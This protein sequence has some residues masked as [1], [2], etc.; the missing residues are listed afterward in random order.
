MGG[1]RSRAAAHEVQV[2]PVLGRVSTRATPASI[3]NSF[4]SYVGRSRREGS[5]SA[6]GRGSLT[7]VH[8]LLDT[9][10]LESINLN[11]R[12]APH[13]TAA[14]V[15]HY[16]SR[17]L[18]SRAALWVVPLRGRR[19]CLDGRTAVLPTLQT[20]GMRLAVKTSAPR[21]PLPTTAEMQC[22][23]RTWAGLGDPQ[24]VGIRMLSKLYDCDATEWQGSLPLFAGL[25]IAAQT[26]HLIQM[27][28][29][30]IGVLPDLQALVPALQRLGRRHLAYNV[31]PRH[32]D[33]MGKALLDAL[34][35]EIGPLFTT[36]D[37]TNM[38]KVYGLFSKAMKDGASSEAS[39]DEWLFAFAP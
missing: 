19:W 7:P 34:A 32:Y 16:A 37:R 3:E 1:A 13:T 10:E 30:A 6:R 4:Y 18:G 14:E 21:V 9:G 23:K 33:V 2:A 27:L 24:Q 39:D 26:R 22:V 29:C 38:S 25:D 15:S 17:V 8:V 36:E 28:G 12:I 11:V 31:V 20:P 35:E 5:L